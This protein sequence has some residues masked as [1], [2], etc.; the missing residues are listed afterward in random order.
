MLCFAYGSNLDWEQMKKRCPSARYCGVAVLPDHRLAFTRRSKTRNCGVADALPEKGSD[1]W[2]VV[3][4]IAEQDVGL[5]DKS[6][7]YRP[8]RENNAYVRG[9]RHVFMDGDKESPLAVMIYFALPEKNPPLPSKEYK[10][11]ILKGA[12]F[13]HLPED[14]IKNVIEPLEVS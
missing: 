11:Q 10:E 9:E 4:E 7:G 14:Y 5:L 3:Y 8:G 6:E 12:R 13:W 2:G 1:V